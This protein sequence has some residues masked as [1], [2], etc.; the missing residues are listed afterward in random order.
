MLS[1]ESCTEEAEG[2][3]PAAQGEKEP[4][5]GGGDVGGSQVRPEEGAAQ[6]GL[7]TG[8][9]GGAV[10]EGSPV[11]WG[12]SGGKRGLSQGVREGP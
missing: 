2:T 11:L 5:G 7:G 12:S 1:A 6:W 8:A 3:G 10:S 9:W 4:G